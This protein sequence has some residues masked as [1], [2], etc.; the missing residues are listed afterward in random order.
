MRTA[1][2]RPFQI[3][4]TEISIGASVGVDLAAPGDDPDRALRAA[5]HAMYA[6]KHL[7]GGRPA[8]AVGLPHPSAMPDAAPTG[9]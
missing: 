4:G 5:D 2:E 3:L 7:G 1:A 6:V 9:S 8:Q